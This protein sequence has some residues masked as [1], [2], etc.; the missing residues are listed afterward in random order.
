MSPIEQY[1]LYGSVGLG[2]FQYYKFNK[3]AYYLEKYA[4][5]KD[6]FL[7]TQYA[8]SA[9]FPPAEL[10]YATKYLEKFKKLKR[11]W[12][13]FPILYIF[14]DATKLILCSKWFKK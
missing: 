5:E 4:F 3:K 12:I 1:G 10:E 13:L 11:N 6:P 8:A 9:S 14:A 7:K 2:V